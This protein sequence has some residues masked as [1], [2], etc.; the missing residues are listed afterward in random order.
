[1]KWKIKFADGTWLESLE[2]R[3]DK[4]A[5]EKTWGSISIEKVITYDEAPSFNADIVERIGYLMNMATNGSEKY[6]YIPIELP[7][8]Q[9]QAE[10][11]KM[12]KQHKVGCLC[13][14]NERCQIC[15][16]RSVENRFI[17][18]YKGKIS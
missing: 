12:I 3:Y 16:S 11:L 1:M 17:E 7:E 14:C 5:P 2:I 13:G 15:N 10:L 8:E 4:D 18:K 6:E 9:L